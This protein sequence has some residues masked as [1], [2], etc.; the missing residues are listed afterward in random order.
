METKLNRRGQF[1]LEQIGMAYPVKYDE[2]MN[3]VLAQE[4]GRYNK[5]VGELQLSL[6]SLQAALRGL[7]VMSNELDAQFQAI[8]VNV[9]PKAWE[10][11]AYP[12]LKPLNA[13]FDDL[14][15]R[16]DFML[17]WIANG[18]PVVFWISGFYFPQGFLTGA[19]QNYARKMGFAIDTV[20]TG[21]KWLDGTLTEYGIC[22]YKHI[23]KR[24]ADG[25]I[26]RGLYME[27]A[28]W[29]PVKKVIDDSR[30]KQLYTECPLL[31]LDPIQH[32]KPATEKVYRF[33]VYK[34]L[35]RRGVLATTGHSTNFI[36]WM[37]MPS[38]RSH[39]INNKGEADDEVWTRAGVAG[40]GS[41]KF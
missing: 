23:T 7:A 34:V 31:H 3:T 30:P 32:W 37:E 22:E 21:Y 14:L 6:P 1:D 20:D 9:V 35:S 39:F 4:A 2:S 36:M 25:V 28:R 11:K 5:L 12:S 19:R 33:P 27:G 26:C 29:N 18:I 15:A 17:D 40:F 38:D 41:L 13:W 8:A 16:L 10:G 24:P